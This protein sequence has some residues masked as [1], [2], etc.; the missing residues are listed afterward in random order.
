MSTLD[1]FGNSRIPDPGA[2]YYTYA[3]EIP[4]SSSYA[5]DYR[6]ANGCARRHVS[7][8]LERF[9]GGRWIASGRVE[10]PVQG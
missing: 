1:Y 7:P 3:G 8:M 5:R 9:D 4:W 2:D 10:V 6:L